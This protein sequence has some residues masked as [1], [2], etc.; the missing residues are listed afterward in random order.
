LSVLFIPNNLPVWRVAYILIAPNFFFMHTYKP[1][2]WL[3]ASLLYILSIHSLSAQCSTSCNPGLP[4][5]TSIT[6][7]SGGTAIQVNWTNASGVSSVRIEYRLESGSYPATPFEPFAFGNTKQ[8]TGLTANTN[9][10]IRLTSNC[11][12][13]TY[14]CS[15]T[16]KCFNSSVNGFT[17]CS[18]GCSAPAAPAVSPGST[19]ALVTLPAGGNITG[20][21]VQ[22]RQGTSGSFT[23]IATNA[24]PPS[25]NLSPPLVASTVYQVQIQAICTGGATSSYSAATQFTTN[26]PSCLTNKDYGKNANDV[27][28]VDAAFNNPSTYSFGSM[29]AVNDGGSVFRSFEYQ[30]SNQITQLTTQFRNFHKMD[31]DFNDKPVLTGYMN[32]V[33][34]PYGSAQIQPQYNLTTKPKNTSPEGTPAYMYYNKNLYNIFKNTHGFTSIVGSTELLFHPYTWKEKIYNENEWSNSG[35]TGIRASYE[36]YTKKFIDEMAPPN[37]TP[38]QIVVTTY[39]VGNELWDYPVKSDY[40]DLLIG[41][42]NAFVTKYGLKS[43]GGWK[44]KFVAGAFQA[45][46]DNN[47]G[48]TQRDF[49]NCGGALERHDFIGDYLNVSDCN[50]LKD[51]DA[52]DCHPY[53]FSTNTTNWTF[54]EAAD[55][56]TRVIR[57][58]AGWWNTNRNTSTGILANAELWSTEFGFNSANVGEKPQMSYLIRGL[59]MHSRYHFAKVYFYNA[60]DKEMTSS[61]NYG[62]EYNSAGFWKLGTSNSPLIANGATAKPSWHAMLDFKGIFSAHVFYKAL[63][64]DSDG[65]V[66][67]LAKPDGTDPYLVFWSPQSTTD[68]NYNTN[69]AINKAVSWASVLSGYQIS[70]TSGQVFKESTNAGQMFTAASGTTCGSTTLTGIRRNPAY[71]R[72]VPCCDNITSAGTITA[73][74]PS[75]GTAPFNPNVIN[76][77]SAASGGSAGAGAITY[78]WQESTDN[79]TFTNI[80]AATGTTYDPPSL[81]QTKYFRRASKRANCSSFLYSNVVTITVT[82]SC[83]NYTD[84]ANGNNDATITACGG[85]TIGATILS[86]SQ[87]EYIKIFNST[88]SLSWWL[89]NPYNNGSVPCNVGS[90]TPVALSPGTYHAEV[91]YTTSSTTCFRN[92]IIVPVSLM[93]DPSDRD[94]SHWENNQVEGGDFDATKVHLFP[95]PT[96]GTLNL[97]LD[98][99]SAQRIDVQVLTPL[100]QSM[101]ETELTAVPGTPLPL[102]LDGLDNGLYFLV[103]TRDNQKVVKRFVKN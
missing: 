52:I 76:S 53:S 32:A 54:P 13:G 17:N 83:T 48:T 50:V 19:N 34:P 86:G 95:N 74:S 70:T 100:G 26:P 5:I 7:Q 45:F 68:A 22:Y 87:I 25:Y 2:V 59:L 16:E 102:N 42:R 35:Y 56:E 72:L 71:I 3:W 91:K 21:N 24:Q 85:G 38:S 89:C 55:S 43:S 78:Q 39:Q 20:Y 73:P 41:A 1:T 103:V 4:T 97:L 27:T 60:Y 99:P 65:Y 23:T 37:G 64:E 6:S 62:A 80:S 46:R 79:N 11:S 8:I 29:I 92:N 81:S 14:S 77:G 44:M 10:R 40:H 96:T 30:S 82:S 15:N 61:G 66:Y 93:G 49:S 31:E 69:I 67:L 36:N 101:S 58:M 18:T 94:K 12:G 51:L 28:G 33:Q 84:C 47:C 57:H 88:Y 98:L 75:S 63:K 9:Y 90:I